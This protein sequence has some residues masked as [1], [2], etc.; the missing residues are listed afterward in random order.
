M[1]EFF[2]M[3]GYGGYVWPSYFASA[4]VLGAIA[5]SI[6]QRRSKLQNQLQ[7]IE[8]AETEERAFESAKIIAAERPPEKTPNA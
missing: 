8:A 3:G 4:I 2:E 7:R 5:W 1:V 6:L